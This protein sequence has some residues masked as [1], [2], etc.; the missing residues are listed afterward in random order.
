VV[1]GPASTRRNRRHPKHSPRIP[2]S[3]WAATNGVA[4][5]FL[6]CQPNPAHLDIVALARRLPRR[7]LITQN[8]GGLHERAGSTGVIAHVHLRGKAAQ[9]GDQESRVE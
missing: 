8:V 9:K 6:H 2:T 3:S 1:C 4:R 5:G 7:T